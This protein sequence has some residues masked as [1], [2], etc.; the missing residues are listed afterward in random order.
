MQSSNNN[1][2]LSERSNNSES[3]VED[4][5]LS[6]K[7]NND[8]ATNSFISEDTN[9]SSTSTCS[10][11]NNISL[12][13]ISKQ[14]SRSLSK[15]SEESALSNAKSSGYDTNTSSDNRSFDDDDVKVF[16]GFSDIQRDCKIGMMNEMLDNLNTEI[17][18]KKQANNNI[19]SNVLTLQENFE[20]LCKKI[21]DSRV[22][23][24]L[25]VKKDESERSINDL[26]DTSKT[27]DE[28]LNE[29]IRDAETSKLPAGVRSKRVSA[30][31]NVGD[32]IPTSSS[33]S[34][35]EKLNETKTNSGNISVNCKKNGINKHI[36]F[37]GSLR[38]TS[39]NN[40][41][42]SDRV[43]KRKSEKD[44]SSSIKI[45]PVDSIQKR[46]SSKRQLRSRYRTMQRDAKDKVAEVK[47]ETKKQ[48]MSE[49]DA[50]EN[51][52]VSE[53]CVGEVMDDDSDDYA[54]SENGYNLRRSN[55][56]K[57]EEC[58]EHFNKLLSDL[59]TSSFQLVADNVEGLKD[60]ISSFTEDISKDTCVD[61]VSL[62][63]LTISSL[64]YNLFL[65]HKNPSYFTGRYYPSV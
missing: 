33:K 47:K 19:K 13:A 39:S 34:D 40:A 30:S 25:T 53:I 60:L 22:E 43:V 12:D 29:I 59:S 14:R 27:D 51:A 32:N 56:P 38:A 28:K 55:R 11:N 45:K 42:L 10:N 44:I 26:T 57:T 9:L 6:Y 65:F 18:D 15:I 31:N 46:R 23:T 50:N 52:F 20:G 63:M 7:C 21:A 16:K 58:K 3:K 8:S 4:K 48:V 61:I 62:I 35:D 54:N 1:N 5:D 64:F 37:N 24:T 36:A 2:N 49:D 41:S 17:D